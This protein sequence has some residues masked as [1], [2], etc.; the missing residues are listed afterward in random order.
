MQMKLGFTENTLLFEQTASAELHQ[1]QI[2]TA[3]SAERQ[4][5]PE[6]G[7]GAAPDEQQFGRLCDA[8]HCGLR[9]TQGPAY[10]LQ[11]NPRDPRRV[12]VYLF[13][14]PTNGAHE[15]ALLFVLLRF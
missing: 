3:A 5:G 6:Q 7:A 11:R 1:E 9:A 15:S 13:F 14:C 2:D 10:R 4:P 12:S 8:R